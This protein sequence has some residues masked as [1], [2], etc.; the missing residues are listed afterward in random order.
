MNSPI[1]IS[2]A[3]RYKKMLINDFNWTEQEIEECNN[4]EIFKPKNI[5]VH[6]KSAAK[7]NETE[8]RQRIDRICNLIKLHI[9]VRLLM[10]CELMT[11]HIDFNWRRMLDDSKESSN[12]IMPLA[13]LHL[14][15]YNA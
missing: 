2:H 5:G 13:P 10:M 9:H 1:V 14:P 15:L 11:I 3:D 12:D 8:D 4:E 6:S 7:L